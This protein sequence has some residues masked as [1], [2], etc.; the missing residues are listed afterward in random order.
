[1]LGIFMRTVAVS[2]LVAVT[3]VACSSSSEKYASTDGFCAALADEECQIAGACAVP[4][5]SC[6]AARKARCTAGAASVAANRKYT[7]G[8]AQACIDKAH[9]YYAA[10]HVPLTPEET[11]EIDEACGKVF[12]GTV[13]KNATCASTFDCEGSLIC[14]KGR[15]GDKTIVKNVSDGCANAGEVCD[16]GLFCATTTPNVCIAKKKEGEACNADNPCLET[17][18]CNVTCSP[19]F[20][21]G[22]ACTSNDDCAPSAPYCDVYS[23]KICDDGIRFA[24]GQ[25]TLCAEFGGTPSP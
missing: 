20:T 12:S 23:G 21:A 4:K 5:D 3:L 10:T 17:L 13:L 8:N 18:L 19:R 24:P 22:Q 14:D 6:T 16:T 1:M 9:T 25:K 7:P 11:A 15:C 2:G